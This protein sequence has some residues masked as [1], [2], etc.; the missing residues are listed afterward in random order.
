LNKW[1]EVLLN[2]SDTLETAIEVLHAG[3]ARIAL[4]VDSNL[5]LL[6]TITDGDIRRALIQ[7]VTMEQEIYAVMNKNPTTASISEPVNSI[8]SAMKRK[9]VLHIPLVDKAGTLVGLETI[10]H[11]LEEKKYD[12]PVFL[13]AGGFGKRLHPLTENRPKP[14]LNV[15]D[16]PILELIITQFIDAGFHRFYIST[17]YKAEMIRDYFG[18][19][20]KWGGSIEYLHED[21]PLGTAGS[22]GLLPDNLS[23]HPILMMNGDL[24]TKI[25]YRH[26]LD[27]HNEQDGLAT[28]CVREYDFQVPYGVVD[29]QNQQLSHIIEKPV[30]KFFVNAGIYVIEPELLNSIDGVAYLD[31]PNF[32]ES[33]IKRG[34]KVS[35]F[36][37]HEYWMDIGRMDEYEQAHKHYAREF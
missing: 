1:T 28:M 35:V 15:G 21:Q 37:I 25:N 6:G 29:I 33:Q 16:R 4:V 17:H 9:G 8:L 2:P 12:N 24:L 11:L 5:K 19:G 27:F 30:H 7:H 20:S 36:P 34:Q 13:M 31:M 14:L 32:L 23:E 22:L 3:G 26:L 10:E 18:D